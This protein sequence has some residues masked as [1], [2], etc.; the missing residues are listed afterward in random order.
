MDP[1]WYDEAVKGVVG[2]IVLSVLLM[3]HTVWHEAQETARTNR[4][5]GRRDDSD[6]GLD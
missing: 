1:I 6:T 2:V 5:G 4:E 3:C